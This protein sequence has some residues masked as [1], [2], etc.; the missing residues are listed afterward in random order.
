M[1]KNRED[2]TERRIVEE[3]TNNLHLGTEEGIWS[4]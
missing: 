4:S 1:D 3:C 2:N